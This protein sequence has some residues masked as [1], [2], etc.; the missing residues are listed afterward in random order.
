M[1]KK[2]D[3]IK[4]RI[5]QLPDAIKEKLSGD[6]VNVESG[7]LSKSGIVNLLNSSIE[8]HKYIQFLNN[9]EELEKSIESLIDYLYIAHSM[10]D[11]DLCAVTG[12]QGV[13]KSTIIE[14]VY[15]K[16]GVILK[17]ILPCVV[18]VGERIPVLINESKNLKQGERKLYAHLRYKNK[19][20]EV[21]LT[22][23]E[24]SESAF[25]ELVLPGL[26]RKTEESQLI[27]GEVML[28]EIQ[29]PLSY[30]KLDKKG[31]ILLPGRQEDSQYLEDLIFFCIS[32]SIKPIF[33]T[34]PTKEAQSA[35]EI[36]FKKLISDY[37]ESR[38]AHPVVCVS[39]SDSYKGKNLE[40][41]KYFSQNNKFKEDYL[42]LTGTDD[43]Y[44]ELPWSDLL[45][46]KIVE[47][48]HVLSK[49]QLKTRYKILK[50][51]IKDTNKFLNKKMAE[52]KMS[53]ELDDESERVQSLMVKLD[54]NIIEL[55]RIIEKEFEKHISAK[56]SPIKAEVR[57][58]LVNT[59]KI[60]R[61]LDGIVDFFFVVKDARVMEE[62]ENLSETV[63]STLDEDTAIAF[64][65]IM[66]NTFLKQL[67]INNIPQ[68]E[69]KEG[70]K[71]FLVNLSENEIANNETVSEGIRK[72]LEFLLL[73]KENIL[74][75]VRQ[76]EKALAIIP[77]LYLFSLNLKIDNEVFKE[78]NINH[79]S[80]NKF[81]NDENL[82]S[83][84]EK[85]K[86]LLSMASLGIGAD[87]FDGSFDS[88]KALKGALGAGAA[89]FTFGASVAYLMVDSAL[90]TVEK[91]ILEEYQ[92][93]QKFLDET[94]DNIVEVHMEQLSVQ[95]EELRKR[96]ENNL[97]DR[98]KVNQKY[99]QIIRLNA[100]TAN[101]ERNSEDLLEKLTDDYN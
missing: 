26:E 65:G 7:E 90:K 83:I 9:N 87:I 77:Y 95:L 19:N 78:I 3:S 55:K 20:G 54:R 92:L 64:Y 38:S 48:S 5:M 16:S 86:I 12:L 27:Q 100:V 81:I 42:I 68:I 45:A 96:V 2:F 79:E 62:I 63:K 24:V 80:E 57:D 33:V 70:Y 58:Q 1:S 72:D 50:E 49:N 30:L 51:K 36:F 52:L 11:Y 85:N 6:F 17:D 75:E 73:N 82:K 22:R 60:E 99:A 46:S 4:N 84:Y 31:F 34:N 14:K 44:E 98:F 37:R 74:P 94:R 76:L 67:T 59:N 35:N 23:T 97:L 89:K 69:N 15:K 88:F 21:N 91:E 71:K 10:L 101:F 47:V 61:I 28:L 25:Q 41:K 53:G 93:K 29:I 13:G 43:Q 56:I 8:L 39:F 32:M 40:F 18:G 66:Q